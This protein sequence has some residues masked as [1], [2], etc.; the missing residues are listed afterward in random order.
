MLWWWGAGWGPACFVE[1][2]RQRQKEPGLEK[3]KLGKLGK[4]GGV[5]H[6]YVVWDNC[7]SGEQT[8]L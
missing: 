4:S 2:D 8:E 1:I 3:V 6:I 5:Q 7:W